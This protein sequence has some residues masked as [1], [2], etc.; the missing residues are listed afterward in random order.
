MDARG[1]REDGGRRRFRARRA[2]RT[3]RRGGSPDGER[4]RYDRIDRQLEFLAAN[5]A[6]HDAEIAEHSKQILQL[7]DVVISV[8]RIVEQQGRQMEEQGRRMEES[9]RRTDERLNALISVVE[10]H[11]TGPDHPA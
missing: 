9:Q 8:A 6:R 3:D 7:A 11:I 1:V 4:E 5:Q 10:R 2:R